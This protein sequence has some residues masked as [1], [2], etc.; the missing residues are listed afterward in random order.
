MTAFHSNWTKP[1]FSRH[2]HIPYTIEDYDLLA[3]VLSALQW[4]KENG[5][6]KMVT[7]TAGAEYY[8]SLGIVHIWDLGMET[9]LDAVDNAISPLAFWAA[10]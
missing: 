4:R 6:I 5:G 8:C 10:R 9:S 2:D 3:T 1:F 7:D